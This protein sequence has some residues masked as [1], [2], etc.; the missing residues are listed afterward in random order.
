MSKDILVVDDDRTNLIMAERLLSDEFH[1]I[2]VSWRW[3]FWQ[4]R[5]RI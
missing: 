2:P 5:N 1:V 4:R 3:S